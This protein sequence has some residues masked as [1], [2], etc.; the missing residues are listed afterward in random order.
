MILS[1]N[2]PLR[3]SM[4]LAFYFTQGVPT[5]LFLTAIPAWI[6]ANGGTTADTGKIITFYM[7]PW[8]WKFIT[9]VVMDRYTYLPMGRRRAWIIGAQSLLVAVFLGSAII[10]PP[11]GE[12][13]L[14]AALAFAAGL[15]ASTQDVGIDGMSVD[16]LHEDERAVAAGLMFGAASLGIAAASFVGGQ[17]IASIGVSAAYYAAAA[18]VATVLLLGLVVR[19]RVGEKLLPFTSGQA[20]PRNLGIQVE[21]WWPLIL[22]SL[23]A[24]L[25]VVSILFLIVSM[26]SSIPFGIAE[27]YHPIL[28]TQVGG[29]AQTDY[30]NMVSASGLAAGLFGMTVGGWAVSRIGEQRAM[31]ILF[32]LLALLA[33]GFGLMHG[34]WSDDALITGIIWGVE[35]LGLMLIVASIPIAMRLCNPAVAAT[36]FTIYMALSNYGRPIGATMVNQIQKVA[37]I[38]YVYFALGGAAIVAI[39]LLARVRFPTEAKEAIVEIEEELPVT[40]RVPVPDIPGG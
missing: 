2:K 24:L 33:I 3:L 37:D 21:A 29:W 39:L 5:G 11:V 20:H 32:A 35:I 38:Q 19:E 31:I 9:A 22:D 14:L 1:E 36:Q 34:R 25:T 17:L 12:I 8:T 6:A 26:T 28:A 30:T 16:I 15:A 18:T 27:T 7:I 23:K 13:G 4:V 40:P 10:A